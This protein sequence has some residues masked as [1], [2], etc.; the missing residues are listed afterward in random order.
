MGPS[1]VGKSTL[2]ACVAGLVTPDGG[3]AGVRGGD[4][5]KLADRRRTLLRRRMGIVYQ[6]FHL[7]P[8]LTVRENVALPFLVDGRPADDAAVDSLIERVGLQSRRAHLPS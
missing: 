6:F 7:V 1:G 8:N 4:G 5:A 2:L 3:A